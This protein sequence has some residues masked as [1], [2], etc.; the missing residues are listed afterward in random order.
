[1][2]Y[3]NYTYNSYNKPNKVN[4]NKNILYNNEN[5]D[6]EEENNEDNRINENINFNPKIDYKALEQR[7][8]M[9]EKKLINQQNMYNDS[10]TINRDINFYPYN[11]QQNLNIFQ[12]GILSEKVRPLSVKTG[13]NF[14][15]FEKNKK[16]QK[17]KKKSKMKGKDE[18]NN[19]DYSFKNKNKSFSNTNRGKSNK[20][21]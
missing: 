15:A 13:N 14:I 11:A 20:K 3:N 17:K 5:N 8:L 10:K 6:I 21:K 12:N 2:N 1:M 9:L 7:V 16:T 19:N 4:T 18:E